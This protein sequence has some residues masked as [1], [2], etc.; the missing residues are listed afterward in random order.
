MG[1]YIV[2]RRDGS[3]SAAEFTQKAKALKQLATEICEDIERMSEDFGGGMS[4]R[5]RY[6]ERWDDPDRIRDRYRDEMMERERYYG[7]R[8][9]Y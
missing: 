2:G 9:R 3:T 5:G 6:R 8:R 1:L 4:E 7:E